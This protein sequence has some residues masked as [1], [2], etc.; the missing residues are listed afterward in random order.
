M[1]L[2]ILFN[3]EKMEFGLCIDKKSGLYIEV[4]GYDGELMIKCLKCKNS[5]DEYNNGD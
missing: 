4:C 1:N 2:E 3:G 5:I